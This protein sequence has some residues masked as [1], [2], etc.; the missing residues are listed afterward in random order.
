M[1]HKQG[2]S[3]SKNT[4][5]HSQ[6]ASCPTLST[7][8]WYG[9]TQETYTKLICDSIAAKFHLP[10]HAPAQLPHHHVFVDHLV[11]RHRVVVL[12]HGVGFLD[13]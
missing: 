1:Q 9:W 11:T 2:G 3:N 10:M 13:W 5:A 8:W 4:N 12:H 6:T 7:L